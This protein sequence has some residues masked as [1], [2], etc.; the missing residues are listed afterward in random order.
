MRVA[1]QIVLLAALAP[2]GW[3]QQ[4]SA[5]NDRMEITLEREQ[6]G[7]WTVVEPGLVFEPGDRLRFRFRANFGGYL[8]VMNQGTSGQYELL[9]PRT[10]T[11]TD[12]RIEQDREYRIPASDAWFRVDGPPGHDIVYWLVTPVRLGAEGGS[13]EY[14]PLPPPP[15]GPVPP[16]NLR[17]RCDDSIFR[18]RGICVDSSAGPRNVREETE[19]PENLAAV[20]HLRSRELVIMKQG[21]RASVS[22]PA[23]EDAPLL[24]E[25]RIAHR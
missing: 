5:D 16:Q 18:A 25:F 2:A 15:S 1:A 14:V 4:P 17:P 6:N 19:L 8:Y 13:P 20:P 21:E 11:G 22:S 7:T 9:F 24:Y 12:N 23:S 10:E 3:T